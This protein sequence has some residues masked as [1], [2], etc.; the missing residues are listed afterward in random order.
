MPSVWECGQANN[1]QKFT[2]T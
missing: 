2:E 1:Q